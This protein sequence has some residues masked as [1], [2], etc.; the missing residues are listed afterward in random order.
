MVAIMLH[1]LYPNYMHC[2]KTPCCLTKSNPYARIVHYVEYPLQVHP[3]EIP[4]HDNRKNANRTSKCTNETVL[5]QGHNSVIH[6][7]IQV[8]VFLLGKKID[9]IEDT[10]LVHNNV[11][12]SSPDN[13]R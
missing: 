8:D 11:N 12:Q 1:L 6:A 7:F 9:N 13:E 10:M 4:L 2:G 5:P 3:D